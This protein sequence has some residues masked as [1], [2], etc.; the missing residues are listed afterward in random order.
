MEDTKQ[1]VITFLNDDRTHLL[2]N[3]GGEEILRGT[4]LLINRMAEIT[5]RPLDEICSLVTE[6]ATTYTEYNEEGDV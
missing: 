1:I 4:I 3:C 2:L 6:V 5:N